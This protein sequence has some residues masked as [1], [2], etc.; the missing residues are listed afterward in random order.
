MYKRQERGQVQ[1]KS[2]G[3]V[4]EELA[5]RLTISSEVLRGPDRNWNVS[6]VR[7]MVAYVLTRRMGFA[8]KEVA[9][10]LGRDQTS[11]STLVSRFSKRMEEERGV[12]E[13]CEGISKI[14]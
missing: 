3:K 7:G 1:R 14:V 12:K 9:A 10:H 5:K 4:V 13:E 6:R 8:V 11:I 2:L